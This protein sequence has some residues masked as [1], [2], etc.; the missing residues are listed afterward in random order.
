MAMLG[1]T[2][3]RFDRLPSTNEFAREM[4]ASGADEGIAVTAREQTA[5]RGRLGRTWSSPA[6]DGLYLSLILRPQIKSDASPVITLAAAVAVAETLKT[7]F[8]IEV[9]IKWPNDVLASGRKICGILIET[10]IEGEQLQYAVMG[11]GVNLAQREFP[12]EIR[13]SAT[14]ILIE[15]GKRVAADDVL[16][17]L[18]PRIESW[19][20]LALGSPDAVIAR[21]SELSTYAYDCAVS[22]ETPGGVIEGLTRGLADTGALVIEEAGGRRREITSGEVRLRK[23]VRSP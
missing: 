8:Q 23:A 12:K 13:D 20:R 1:S 2:V 16:G 22:V 11:I 9:D 4:A 21:W 18:L 5:G 15:S 19:Y 6:G 3:L 10:A 14:S 7:D 17:P